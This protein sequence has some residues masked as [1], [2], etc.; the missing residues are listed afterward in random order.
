MKIVKLACDN[1]ESQLSDYNF[2]QK[3]NNC[4]ANGEIAQNALTTSRYNLKVPLEGDRNLVY[5]SLTGA[6]VLMEG[7]EESSLASLLSRWP[8]SIDLN[9][10]PSDAKDSLILCGIL[11]SDQQPIN[12]II[13]IRERYLSARNQH[14]MTVTI[15]TTQ[16]CNLACFYCYETRSRASLIISDID[17]ILCFVRDNLVKYDQSSIYIKWYGG[18]PLLNLHFLEECSTR[19]QKLCADMSV[20]YNASITSNGTLWPDNPAEFAVKHRINKVQLTFD[21]VDDL[22]SKTRCLRKGY[23]IGN[24]SSTFTSAFGL[25][26]ILLDVTNVNVRYNVSSHSAH[27]VKPF[28]HRVKNAG[29]LDKRYKCTIQPARVSSYSEGTKFDKSIELSKGDFDKVLSQFDAF[30]GSNDHFVTDWYSNGIEPK[31]TVCKALKHLSFVIGADRL[32]YSCGLQVGEKHRA[33]G[34]LIQKSQSDTLDTHDFIDKYFW[35]EYDP[36][37]LPVCKQC[38]FLPICWGGC[39]KFRLE[40]NFSTFEDI[41]RFYRINLP[42]RIAKFSN[43][44]ALKA[45]TFQFSDQFKCDGKQKNCFG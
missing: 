39:P 2:S 13:N 42:H 38:S 35:S 27:D 6:I 22:H 7:K 4:T 34:K 40:N 32:I 8:F 45:F 24:K 41:S 20:S 9:H 36:T 37:N 23:N 14:P 21:G 19:L 17:S 18:E 26:G 25:V 12:E 30:T 5:N 29:W 31:S 1:L 44:K 28:L 11:H 15:T 43:H 33:I 10:V 3:H 16:D